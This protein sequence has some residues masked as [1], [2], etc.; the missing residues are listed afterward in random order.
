M[1]IPAIPYIMLVRQF[2]LAKGLRFFTWMDFT[3]ASKLY[4]ETA[5]D[6]N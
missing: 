5:K 4:L 3:N 6:N 1:N 2:A